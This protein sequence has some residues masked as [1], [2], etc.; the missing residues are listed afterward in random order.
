MVLDPAEKV[1]LA[2]SPLQLGGVMGDIELAREGTFECDA[3]G[4][5]I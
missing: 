1:I 5:G 3:G 4:V 2:V